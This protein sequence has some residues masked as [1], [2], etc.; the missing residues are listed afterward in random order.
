MT[1]LQ[2]VARSIAP[3]RT[4]C[5][6]VRLFFSFCASPRFARLLT[7]P[8][9]LHPVKPVAVGI[10]PLS[11]PCPDTFLACI[12]QD[13]TVKYAQLPA[14]AEM[15]VPLLLLCILC[16]FELL[17]TPWVPFALAWVWQ[18]TLRRE[19][20]AEGGCTGGTASNAAISPFSFA[21]SV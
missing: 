15:P 12:L 20:S 1:V 5:H 8:A 17:L 16:C 10:A 9:L 14:F 7:C 2:F 19:L 18:C 6:A 11:S 3:E 21:I 13:Y 4:T